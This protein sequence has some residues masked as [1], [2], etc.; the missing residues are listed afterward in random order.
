[1]FRTSG[2][3]RRVSPRLRPHALSWAVCALL[4]QPFVAFAQDAQTQAAAPADTQAAANDGVDLDAIVITA[5]AG[6]KSKL[7]TSVSTS[8]LGIDTLER[9]APRST[10]EI[11]RNI[12]GVRSES[13]GGEGNAN[14][15]VRGL[16]CGTS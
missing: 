4:T 15:A 2:S 9:S 10:A 1:M 6:G 8:S 11:F 7:R 3:S 14:I 5:T 16:P 13:T 12:P